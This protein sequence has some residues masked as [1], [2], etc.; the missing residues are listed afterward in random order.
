MSL[1]D[2][3]REFPFI[4]IQCEEHWADWR[5]PDREGCTGVTTN[6]A[7][8]DLM[9]IWN[10]GLHL[11]FHDDITEACDTSWWVSDYWERLSVLEEI[12]RSY[13]KCKN[14]LNLL[15]SLCQHSL[16][17]SP[18]NFSLASPTWAGAAAYITIILHR[19]ARPGEDEPRRPGEIFRPSFLIHQVRSGN[20]IW[21]GS[22][23]R[24][25]TIY[26]LMP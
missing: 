4:Y 5:R 1:G 6:T 16:L 21:N 26:F 22:M 24:S 3:A 17:C 20:I 18:S 8:L 2:W 25:P 7:Q 19:A 13:K 15:P 9:F 10:K 23:C 11:G 14:S 12:K